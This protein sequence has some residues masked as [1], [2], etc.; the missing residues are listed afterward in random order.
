[1]LFFTERCYWRASFDRGGEAYFDLRRI[2]CTTE[3]T[4][5]QV[6]GEIAQKD[7]EKDQKQGWIFCPTILLKTLEKFILLAYLD[8]CARKSSEKE[9]IHGLL[10]ETT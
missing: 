3:A 4:F 7:P 2:P 10:G 1:M 9:G 5:D 6:R 8:L